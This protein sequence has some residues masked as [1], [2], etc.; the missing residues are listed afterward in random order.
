VAQNLNTFI[1]M[2]AGVDDETWR[3]HLRSGDISKWFEEALKDKELVDRVR[4]I[5]GD[6]D[7]TQEAKEQIIDAIRAKYTQPA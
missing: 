1:R 5:E 2:A 7:S 6:A 4:S 3:H